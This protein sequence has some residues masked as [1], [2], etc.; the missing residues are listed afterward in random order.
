MRASTRE[1]SPLISSSELLSV[2]LDHT[3]DNQLS[4]A[5]WRLPDQENRHVIISLKPVS[6]EENAEI[7]TLTPGFIFAPFER[8]FA[9]I[10]LPSE[11]SFTFRDGRVSPPS[12]QKEADSHTW[13]SG[14][15]K[16]TNFAGKRK[17][18][19]YSSGENI[20]TTERSHYLELVEKGINEIEKG[21]FQKVVPSR[22]RTLPLSEHFD[23]AE[24]FEKLCRTYPHAFVSFVSSPETGTWMGATPEELVRVMDQTIFKT[25]ALAGTQPYQDGTDLKRVAWTQK[26]I[27]EQALVG[28][29]IISCFK[30]IRLREYEEQGPKT[31]IAGNVIH[32]KSDFTVNLKEAGFPQLGSL[33]L[34]LLHPTSAVCGMPLDVSREFLKNNEGYNR[35][36]Y[37]GYLG[38]VNINQ[39]IDLFVNLRCMQLLGNQAVFYAGAGVTSESVPEHEWEETELKLKTI[40]SVIH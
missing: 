22:T 40:S 20:S 1:F 18:I 28:R 7:E 10:Y 8:D 19:P 24:A 31:V 32:L 34:K 30:K 26:E 4:I 9:R 27:E 39:D 2:L 38:P 29:Y 5:I 36:F 14:I 13:L 3:F 12:N 25:V 17:Y 35:R 37:S 16:N 11:Y 33:M 23:P 6:L 21:I 15:L